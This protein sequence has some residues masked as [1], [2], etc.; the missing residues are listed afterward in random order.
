MQKAKNTYINVLKKKESNLSYW[1]YYT[2][3][4][5]ESISVLPMFSQEYLKYKWR[6]SQE[7]LKYKW[8]TENHD[9]DISFLFI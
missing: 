7:Y 4:L 2:N 1:D 3:E 8:R 5:H 9:H 6:F